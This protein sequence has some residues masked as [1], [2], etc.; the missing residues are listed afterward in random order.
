[1]KLIIVTW[2][3]LSA[4]TFIIISII[5]T[6]HNFAIKNLSDS[7]LCKLNY[8]NLIPH[9]QIMFYKLFL[10]T[11]DLVSKVIFTLIVLLEY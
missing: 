4:P 10:S 8:F 1:M 7:F 6:V 9:N 5:G 3:E 11:Y 2:H